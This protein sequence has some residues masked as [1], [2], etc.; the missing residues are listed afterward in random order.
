MSIPV[1]AGTLAAPDVRLYYELRGSGPLVGLVGSPMH[2]APFAGLAEQLAREYTVLT[3]DPRGH[4]GSALNDPE[5]DSTPELRAQDLARLLRHIAAGPAV[6][7][8][9]SGGAITTLALLQSA[10]ELVS[11]AVAHEPPL[12]ELLDDRPAMRARRKDIVATFR[13]DEIAGIR[14]FFSYAELELPEDR[15][16]QM[17]GNRA[18]ADIANDRYFYLHELEGTSG[19]QPDLDALRGVRDRLVIGIGEASAGV[20]CDRTSRALGAELGIEPT[21]FPGGHVG[22]VENPAVFAARLREVV[23]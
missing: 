4:F 11:L 8:G 16:Q 13:E 2:A 20:F 21:L 23:G 3:T 6:V 18:P 17:F 14:K 5:A 7:L 19:W 9:S 22:F 1:T 12:A 15:F 10:P